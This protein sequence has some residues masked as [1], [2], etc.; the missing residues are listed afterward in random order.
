[1]VGPVETISGGNVVVVVVVVATPFAEAVTTR[2]VATVVSVIPPG[3]I[4]A[5]EAWPWAIVVSVE[6][7]LLL[8]DAAIVVPEDT[9]VVDVDDEEL[10]TVVDELGTVVVVD[11]LGTV[12]LVVDVVVEVVVVTAIGATQFPVGAA[13]GRSRL[14]AM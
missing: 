2:G 7:A 6:T 9:T 13:P 1:M 8:P 4:V 12:V 10:G 14:I 11:D 3:A 5:I